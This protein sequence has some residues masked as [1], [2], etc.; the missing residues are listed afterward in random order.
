M[1]KVTVIGLGAV[2]FALGVTPIHWLIWL[3][4]GALLGLLLTWYVSRPTPQERRLR[5]CIREHP[6]QQP[7]IHPL[8][9]HRDQSRF[10]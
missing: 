1:K 10:G 7:R 5:Q 9:R 3:S 4:T 2:W 6:R 8:Y